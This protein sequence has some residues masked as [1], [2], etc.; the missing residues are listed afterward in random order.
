MPT[1]PDSPAAADRAL[2]L[3]VTCGSV[4]EAQRIAQALVE[5][6]LAACVQISAIDSV[7]R[8]EGAVCS[9]PEWRLLVKTTARCADAA[10][11]AIRA[12]HSYA[13]PAIVGVELT[14]VP[15]EVAAWIV[16]SCDAAG[17]DAADPD[18]HDPPR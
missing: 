4:G 15:D 12:L 7:Y 3:L 18:R 17:D 13:L 14:R 2:A 16:A 11:A 8:W 6:R 5:R 9:D 10:E 1:R